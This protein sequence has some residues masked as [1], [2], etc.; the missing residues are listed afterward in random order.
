MQGAGGPPDIKT[1]E[2]TEKKIIEVQDA[3]KH[4]KNN[5]PIENTTAPTTASSA[6]TPTLE[7]P[8]TKELAKL[9]AE[10]THLKEIAS[11][12]TISHAIP[13]LFEGDQKTEEA[14]VIER[15]AEDE[16]DGYQAQRDLEI[17]SVD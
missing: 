3:P 1:A 12:F 9:K 6:G 14:Y 8:L 5:N 2:A 10:Q 11:C 16:K 17:V 15:N 7:F 4:A 13:I